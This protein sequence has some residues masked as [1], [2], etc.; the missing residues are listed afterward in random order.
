VV[1]VGE[2]STHVKELAV[3]LNDRGGMSGA[4]VPPP[5]ARFLDIH[6]SALLPLYP[7]FAQPLHPEDYIAVGVAMCYK[8][9]GGGKLDGTC[10]RVS[11]L[12]LSRPFSEMA[13]VPPSHFGRLYS[14]GRVMLLAW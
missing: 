4:V 8:I 13:K 6:P 3:S 9:N 5:Q 10:S 12:S 7:P 14:V 11:F 1:N 2:G